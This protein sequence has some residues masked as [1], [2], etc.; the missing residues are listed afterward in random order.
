MTT[1]ENEY[2][3]GDPMVI[4]QNLAVDPGYRR[5]AVACLL[6]REAL[7]GNLDFEGLDHARGQDP[8]PRGAWYRPRR[9]SS[10]GKSAG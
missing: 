1:I 4:V 10:D 2:D 8:P 7:G 3:L 6:L 5:K 9:P